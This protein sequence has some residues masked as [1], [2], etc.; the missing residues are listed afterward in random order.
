[1]ERFARPG[2]E[3]SPGAQHG[4][5]A[6]DDLSGESHHRHHVCGELLVFVESIRRS[7]I[8]PRHLEVLLGAVS[9]DR[10][11]SAETAP[12]PAGILAAALIRELRPFLEFAVSP[13]EQRGFIHSADADI[14]EPRLEDGQPDLVDIVDAV[15]DL[16]SAER[17][18]HHLRIVLRRHLHAFAVLVIDD[19][20]SPVGDHDAVGSAEAVLDVPG[21]IHSLLDEHD[22]IGA[23]LL[24]GCEEF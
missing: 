3:S 19:V 2:S 5:Q 10:L 9:A 4:V 15:E 16:Q 8:V 18:Q 6:K 24:R 14:A 21:K 17:I 13:F 22:G 23:G 12:F 1:M 11:R 7:E 20:H